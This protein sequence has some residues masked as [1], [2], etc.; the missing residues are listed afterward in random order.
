MDCRVSTDNGHAQGTS[1]VGPVL[2]R[3]D[4]SPAASIIVLGDVDGS[5]MVGWGAILQEEHD[6]GRMRPARYESGVY[7]ARRGGRS[8]EVSVIVH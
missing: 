8:S 2:T 6:N 7:G 3:L 5:T 4:Y 1:I